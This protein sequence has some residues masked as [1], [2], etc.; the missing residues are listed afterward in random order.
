MRVSLLLKALFLSVL[1][2]VIAWAVEPAFAQRGGHGG[3][4]GFHGGG[5]AAFHGGG[6]GFHGSGGYHGGGRGYYGGRHG[7]GYYGGGYYRSGYRG[8]S[9]RGGY[10]GYPGYRWGWGSGWGFGISVGWGSY[11]PDYPYAYGYAPA[12]PVPYYP[13]PY[14]YYA[15][16]AGYAAAPGYAAAAPNYLGAYGRGANS[17]T[18]SPAREPALAA[19]PGN[20]SVTVMNASYRADPAIRP[21]VKTVIRALQGMPPS[22]RQAQLSR[23]T[24]LSPAERDLV[25]QVAAVPES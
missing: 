20:S 2:I 14:Y 1:L 18:V 16:P 11:W 23:Y 9:Y 8:G 4:G 21:E 10:W 5:G 22:A 25:I 7:G 15:A 3:G 12:W 17:T 6:G 24:N 19:V 13:Y